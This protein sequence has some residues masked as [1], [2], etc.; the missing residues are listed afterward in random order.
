MSN[1]GTLSWSCGLGLGEPCRLRHFETR[2]CSRELLSGPLSP[3]AQYHSSVNLH[4]YR[5]LCTNFNTSVIIFLLVC[6]REC[7]NISSD[8]LQSRDV[9]DRYKVSPDGQALADL[10]ES[11][12]KLGEQ[13]R[14]FPGAGRHVGVGASQGLVEKSGDMRCEV[15]QSRNLQV[16]KEF[17]SKT[18]WLH[19]CGKERHGKLGNSQRA[20]RPA[21]EVP[22]A[23]DNS[24]P[25]Q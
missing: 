14:E 11:R 18:L 23:M 9:G 7:V 17:T 4:H 19:P 22:G 21:W 2:M 25:G 1:A 16:P 24:I 6:V 20:E 10:D 8:L 13:R 5:S 12:P 3:P 15:N